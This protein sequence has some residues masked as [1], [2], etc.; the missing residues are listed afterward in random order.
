MNFVPYIGNREQTIA[1]YVLGSGLKINF[2]LEIGTNYIQRYQYICMTPNII[3][4]T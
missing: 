4:E 1:Q 3:K 2:P